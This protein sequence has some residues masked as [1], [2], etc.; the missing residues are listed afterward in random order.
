MDRI[1]EPELLDALAANEKNA[2]SS[3]ADLR[4]INFLMGNAT[5]LMQLLHKGT[6]GRRV[7]CL[8]ELGAGDGTLLLGLARRLAPEWGPIACIAV[9]QQLEEALPNSDGRSKSPPWT[10]SSGWRSS[11]FRK[12]P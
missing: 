6:A 5:T 12:T 2:L 8:V 1:V 9:D 3:R 10:Y 4:R 11:V 7:S